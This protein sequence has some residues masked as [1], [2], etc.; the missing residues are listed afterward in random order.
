MSPLS[1]A[2]PWCGSLISHD[3]FKEIETRIR[4]QEKERLREAEAAMHKRVAAEK[5]A[6]ENK[7]KRE[8]DKRIAGI[9]L[10]RDK[11]LQMV[12][13]LE[14]REAAVRKEAHDSIES[15][16][17]TFQDAADKQHNEEIKKIRQILDK[18]RGQALLKQQAD[19]NRER[20]TFQKKFKQM[21]QQLQRKTS[22]EIGDGAEI[23]LFQS[24]CDEFRGDQI[25]RVKKGTLGADIIHDVVY[26]GETCGRIIYDSKKRQAWQNGFVTKLR[27]DQVEAKAEHA[28]LTT[29]EFPRTERELCIREG[30]IVVSPARAVHI[31]HLLRSAILRLHQQ[32][33][34]IKERASKMNSLYR[35]IT[36]P[37]YT[38]RMAEAMRLTDKVLELDVV[39]ERE[40]QKVWKERG[41]LTRRLTKAL[42]QIDTD[43]NAILEASGGE[44]RPV[45]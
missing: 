21:E 23:D 16:L 40:H 27:Q 7:S 5:L 42:V 4:K 11:N 33:L 44:L 45:A 36:S 39:E 20:E 13:K 6:I 25:E 1:D 28:I 43:V 12:K 14:A 26:K 18:D 37:D 17:K 19:F 10:E 35:F 2:C 30:V 31:V 38:Q 41:L 3:K 15:R 34:S 29:T 24:L 9:T 22:N 8:A 32:G